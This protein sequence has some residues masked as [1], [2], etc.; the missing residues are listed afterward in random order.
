MYYI[1]MRCYSVVSSI[2][3]NNSVRG[4]N[5]FRMHSWQDPRSKIPTRLL[6]KSWIL[7]SGKNAFWTRSFGN[8]F[9]QASLSLR[10]PSDIPAVSIQNGQVCLS[11]GVDMCDSVRTWQEHF[12]E[13]ACSLYQIRRL[14]F[15]CQVRTLLS[16]ITWQAFYGDLS[17][18][19]PSSLSH[20]PCRPS[21]AASQPTTSPW[22]TFP[23]F[24]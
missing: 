10:V 4:K 16:N 19:Q 5:A 14:E 7:D 17:R 8:A 21:Q 1:R 13:R 22:K 9:A 6:S 2:L 15:P 11:F 20:T 12:I 18:D 23:I 3:Y 24:T